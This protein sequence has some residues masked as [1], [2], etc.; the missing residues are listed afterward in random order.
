VSRIAVAFVSVGLTAAAVVIASAGLAEPAPAVN[1]AGAE[2][3]AA[4]QGERRDVLRDAAEQAQVLFQNGRAEYSAVQRLTIALLNAEL[5][6][7][8]DRAARI[9]VR[10][11]ILKQRKATEELAVAQ[12][13]AARLAGMTVLEAKADRLQAEIE[14]LREKADEK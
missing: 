14:L 1:A 5:D 13:A 12:K 2:K 9:A 10:E 8:P 11:Q 6:L 7:A 4:L 3:L